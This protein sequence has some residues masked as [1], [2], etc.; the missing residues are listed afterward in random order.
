MIRVTESAVTAVAAANGNA[1]S[2]NAADQSMAEIRHIPSGWWLVLVALYVVV[3]MLLFYDTAASIVSIWMRSQT[4]AHG[5]LVVPISLWLIWRR[6]EEL[7]LIPPKPQPWVLI[8]IVGGGLAWSLASMVDVLIIQQLS[9]VGILITGIWALLG[10]RIVRN[11]VFPLGFLFMA[12]PMGEELIMPLTNLTADSAEYLIRATG[13]PLLREGNFLTLPTGKWSVVEACSGIRY[14]IASITLGL[15][16]AYIAYRSWWKRAIFVIASIVV[17][18]AANSFRAYGV[19]MIGHLSNMK[20]GVGADHLYY[21]WILFGIVMLLLFWIGSF[22]EDNSSIPRA[23]RDEATAR[24]PTTPSVSSAAPILLI[25]LVVAALGP[26]LLW[27]MSRADTSV[28]LAELQAPLATGSW[29]AATDPDW[30]WAPNQ[31]GAD[32]ELEHYY[33]K[34]EDQVGLFLS[35]YLSQEQGVELVD[36]A[37]PWRTG[38]TGWHVRN[39]DSLSITF[40]AGSSS[41]RIEEAIV[42]SGQQQ[43]LVWTWYRIDGSYTT[44]QY[45]AKL[46]EARQQVFQGYREGSRWFLA[47]PIGELAAGEAPARARALLQEFLQDHQSSIEHALDSHT[48]APGERK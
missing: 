34:D 26:T 20:Y 9:L 27:A 40:D 37:Q 23:S 16:Y 31:L 17:P 22:W 3:V 10:T 28:D 47:T 32:R 25:A 6:R 1:V 14:L 35:Q 42:A 12:V 24:E 19:V 46:Y 39:R 4:F 44:N 36:G 15:V 29:Q 2:Q 45:L 11:I 33:R 21:G 43:L 5:F 41:V 38:R 30:G 13:V 48:V 8:L 18:I 7:A